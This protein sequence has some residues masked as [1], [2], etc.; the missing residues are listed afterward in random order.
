MEDKF[1]F[2]K[3]VVQEEEPSSTKRPY[4]PSRSGS[5]T[6]TCAPKT[7]HAMSGRLVELDVTPTLSRSVGKSG[8][9]MWSVHVEW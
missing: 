4:H 8:V 3:V 2:N 1:V 6:N 9:F 5:V 7:R